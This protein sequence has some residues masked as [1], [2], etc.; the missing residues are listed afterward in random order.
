MLSGLSW[1]WLAVLMA[2]GVALDL[3]LG[4][5]RRWHP[6]VGFGNLAKTIERVLN[7]RPALRLRGVLAWSLAVPPPV[8]LAACLLAAAPWW[9]AALLHANADRSD[10]ISICTICDAEAAAQAS[11]AWAS[12]R[13]SKAW[14]ACG[15]WPLTP[16]ALTAWKTT[17]APSSHPTPWRAAR[18]GASNLLTMPTEMTV[19]VCLKP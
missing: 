13:R 2:L 9:L 17:L 4:E 16:T 8:L 5:P 1:P 18:N 12:R 11:F 10:R 15:R 19:T 7:Q 14:T 6:L 3:A